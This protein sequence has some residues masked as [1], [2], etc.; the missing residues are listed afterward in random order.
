MTGEKYRGG[1]VL[2]NF[3][4][5][6]WKLPVFVKNGAILPMCEPN[7][8]PDE[9]NRKNRIVEFWPEGNHAFTTYEDDG[10]YIYNDVEEVEGSQW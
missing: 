9:I 7:N 4:V 6:L 1:Q 2:N 3:A 5:P 10:K 8:T